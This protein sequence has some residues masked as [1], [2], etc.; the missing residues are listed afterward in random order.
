VSEPI[1]A[2][3]TTSIAPIPIESN[4]LLRDNSMPAIAISTVM[5]DANTARR[6][7]AAARWRAS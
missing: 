1:I 7:V 4:T 3:K 2:K 5:P 6:D